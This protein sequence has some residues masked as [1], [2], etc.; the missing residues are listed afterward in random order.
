MTEKHSS[1]ILLVDDEDII[2]R[3]IGYYLSDAGYDINSAYDGMAALKSIEAN[4]YD[5]VMI[6]IRMPG[7]DGISLLSKIQEIRPVMPVVIITGYATMETVIQALRLGA[8][9]FL[10]KPIKL[11]ELEAVIEKCLNLRALR[12]ER[13]RLREAIGAI[14]ALRNFQAGERTFIGISPATLSIREQIHD[15]V[16]LACDTILITGETGTGKEVVARQIHFE[17][18]SDQCPF[19]ALSCPAISESLL[20]SELFGHVKGAFTGADNNRAGYFELADGGT[21]F[22]DEVADISLS[23]QA[24]LLRVLDT[25]AFRRVGG[26]K[27]IVTNIRV[28]AASNAPLEEFVEEGRFR[29]DLYYRLN[30]YLIHL[31][32]L[33][34]RPQD[35]IPLAEHFLTT[36][37]A[38]RNFRFN[39]FSPEAQELLLNYNFPG[40]ARELRNIIERAAILCRTGQIQAEHLS[41][42]RPVKGEIPFQLDETKKGEE[43]TRILKVLEHT[44][45]NRRQAAKNLCMPY[46]TLRYKMKT[47]NID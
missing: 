36:Y 27:E 7:M 33:R 44:K 39:G 19:I 5:L 31:P 32:P 40:N 34:D 11:L 15:A 8:A 12:Q 41:L 29:R 3:S 2:H 6:D 21:L 1:R 13:L 46:S 37:S 22:L 35:I 30:V 9:D 10:I 42:Q 28:I 38:A 4:N 16:E 18:G 43:R 25:R 23:A 45:W 17:A 24:M 26:S 47:L 20:E 14:Q